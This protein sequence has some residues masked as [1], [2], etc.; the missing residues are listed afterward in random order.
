MNRRPLLVVSNTR[1]SAAI[2]RLDR[3]NVHVA[4]DLAVSSY[5]LAGD[6]SAKYMATKL[7]D[8]R[9]LY[10]HFRERQTGLFHSPL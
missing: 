9:S 7:S 2:Y 1:I 5:V 3:S 10:R 8:D 6:N 4:D